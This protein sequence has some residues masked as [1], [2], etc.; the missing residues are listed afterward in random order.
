VLIGLGAAYQRYGDGRIE[1]R[2]PAVLAHAF[3]WDDLYR[4]LIVTPLWAA[5]S[6]LYHAVEVPIIMGVADAG[7]ALVATAGRE[8]RR[9]QSGYLRSYALLFAGAALVAV[10]LVGLGLR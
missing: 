6:D 5:G 8:V 10:V 7:A 9:L 4:K 1:E 2:A 3:F